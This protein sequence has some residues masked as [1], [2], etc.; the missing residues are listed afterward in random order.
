[1]LA[2]GI[3]RRQ[4][5][6]NTEQFVHGLRRGDAIANTGHLEVVIQQLPD[7]GRHRRGEKNNHRGTEKSIRGE[8]A[9]IAALQVPADASVD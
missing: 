7:A 4:F 5:L 2:I 6:T 1:M 9:S 3:I 8:P